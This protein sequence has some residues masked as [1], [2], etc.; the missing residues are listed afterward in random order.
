ML[1]LIISGIID[2]G[3]IVGRVALTE[4]VIRRFEHAIFRMLIRYPKWN[5]LSRVQ[6]RGSDQ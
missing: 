3:K 5:M 6:E 2:G 4:G 1:I